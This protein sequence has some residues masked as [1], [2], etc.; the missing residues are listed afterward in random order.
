MKFKTVDIEIGK[1]KPYANNA[2]IHTP[3]QVDALAKEI[4]EVGYTQPIV[5]TH[6]HEIVA[7][8]GRLEALKT[9]KWNMAPCVVLPKTI[10]PARIKAMRLFDN[11]IAETSWDNGLLAAELELIQAADAS[12]VTRSGFDES[13]VLAFLQT[14]A[15]SEGFDLDPD[16]MPNNSKP[17]GGEDLTPTEGFKQ[18]QILVRNDELGKFT[19]ACNTTADML[20]TE[21]VTD[22]IIQAIYWMAQYANNQAKTPAV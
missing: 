3:A 6:D 9:L 20:G 2:K 13:E 12:L 10:D 5:V 16:L 22:T 18:M 7:G 17:S 8:H 4:E 11:K 1:L 19:A 21:T 14:D 15:S